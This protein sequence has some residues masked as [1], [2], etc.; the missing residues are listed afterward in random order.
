[1]KKQTRK[2]ETGRN[3]LEKKALCL[4]VDEL[5]AILFKEIGGKQ[6]ISPGLG[7]SMDYIEKGDYD[8]ILTD[9]DSPQFLHII[10]ITR[11]DGKCKPNMSICGSNLAAQARVLNYKGLDKLYREYIEYIRKEYLT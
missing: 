4:F 1:M 3:S 6:F 11:R 7:N 2:Q 10:S 9:N 8:V 5:N